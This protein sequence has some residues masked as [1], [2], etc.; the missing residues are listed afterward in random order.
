MKAMWICRNMHNLENKGSVYGRHGRPSV[1]VQSWW[2]WRGAESRQA[3]SPQHTLTCMSEQAGCSRQLRSGGNQRDAGLSFSQTELRG[4]RARA[5][6]SIH[7]DQKPW[8]TQPPL[9]CCVCNLVQHR[10]NTQACLM[11]DQICII[12]STDARPTMRVTHSGQVP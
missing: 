11:S 1:T 6:S 8:I 3:P 12:S 2:F 9:V 4:S 5:P 7:I 10:H